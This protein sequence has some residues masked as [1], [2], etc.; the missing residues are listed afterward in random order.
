MRILATADIHIG[1]RSTRLPPDADARTTSSAAAWSSIVDL[2]VAQQVDVV[3]IAGDLV[4][5]DNRFYEALGPLERGLRRLAERGIDVVAV[6][7]NHDYDVLPSLARSL[8][9]GCLTLVGSG[10][11]WER[12]TLRRGDRRLHVDGWSFPT[13][14]VRENPLASR[15]LPPPPDG[16]PVLGMLHADLDSAG[17]SYAP[18]SLGSLHATPATFWLLGHV[19]CSAFFE[20]EGLPG[21]LYPGSP[22]PMDPGEPGE[23]GVWMLELAAGQVPVRTFVPLARVRYEMMDVDI[24]DVSTDDLRQRLVQSM[25]ARAAELVA[26]PLEHLS[27]RLRLT[28]RTPLHRSIDAAVAR[29]ATDLQFDVNGAAIHVD[30]VECDTRPVRDMAS[31]ASGADAAAWLAGLITLLDAPDAQGT[32]NG[33]HD[34]RDFDALIGQLGSVARTVRTAR[35]MDALP[36]SHEHIPDERLRLDLRRGAEL[37]LDELLAQKEGAV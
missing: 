36:D 26:P 34:R 1:R 27:F 4:D 19:H 23:H 21:V 33:T 7:G 6:A 30:R 18:V 37:L 25:R 29:L 17:S 13:R 31:L 8:P 14:H 24:T 12:V 5:H 35:G 10:G 28:G 15:D 20:R 22:N 2:A 32:T 11:R 16:T 3:A 9:E